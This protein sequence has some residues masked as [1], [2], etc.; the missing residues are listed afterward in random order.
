MF[1]GALRTAQSSILGFYLGDRTLERNIKSRSTP[2]P[3]LPMSSQ[4][5]QHI[6]RTVGRKEG[7]LGIFL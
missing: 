6:K 2:L 3:L 1:E 5:A 7:N 4:Y